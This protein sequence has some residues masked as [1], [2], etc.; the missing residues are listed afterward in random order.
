MPRLAAAD[1]Q[2]LRF[3]EPLDALGDAGQWHRVVEAFHFTRRGEGL[4]ILRLA[5][6]GKRL[7]G[8][9]RPVHA[10]KTAGDGHQVAQARGRDGGGR[11]V[12]P[13]QIAV[14]AQEYARPAEELVGHE[15]GLAEPADLRQR[16]LQVPFQ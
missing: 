3:P 9:A 11:D 4:S 14:A 8:R 12:L 15:H 10:G 2:K 1:D 16:P 5:F 13:A 7:G 6:A